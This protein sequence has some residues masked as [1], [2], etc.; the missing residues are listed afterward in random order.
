M[1]MRFC[2]ARQNLD[3]HK[4]YGQLLHCSKAVIQEEAD[5]HQSR[6]ACICTFADTDHGLP[7]GGMMLDHRHG[8]R[9][10]NIDGDNLAILEA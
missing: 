8:K 6:H 9:V 10:V 2:C 5:I 4:I 3:C 7:D 1:T